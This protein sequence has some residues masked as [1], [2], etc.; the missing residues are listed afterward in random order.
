M[1]ILGQCISYH[2]I[3][4]IE[5][6]AMFESLK[7]NLFTSS[8][9]RLDPQCSKGVTWDNFECF[10]ET[11]RGKDT[12]HDTAGIAYPTVITYNSKKLN[13][14]NFASANTPNQ[15]SQHSTN[16]KCQRAYEA[17]SLNIQRHTEKKAKLKTTEFLSDNDA[18]KKQYG[19]KSVSKNWK[20]ETLWIL[21]L[22]VTLEKLTPL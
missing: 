16:K 18:L 13:I 14:T 9:T 3:E 17:T 19:E 15:E 4:E 7:N 6:E 5:T 11:I 22:N 21:E 1:N 12:L 8:G 2:I 10:V 20:L